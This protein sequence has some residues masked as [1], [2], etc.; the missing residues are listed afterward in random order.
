[1]LRL[2]YFFIAIILCPL[3]IQGQD[4]LLFENFNSCSF[5]SEW[6][7]KLTGNQ[8][9]KW[10]V[11]LP[12]NSK[13]KESSING[14]CMLYIDDDLTGDKT[15]PFKLRI[16]TP[17][18]DGSQYTDLQLN[19]LVHFRR[20]KTEYMKIIVDNGQKEFVIREFKGRNYSGEL[21][22]N[23]INMT[24][25]LSYYVSDSMRIIIEYD[26]DNQWAWWAG[27]D[28]ISITGRKGGKIILGETFNDCRLPDGWST[29]IVNGVNDW[30]FGYFTDGRSIDGSC[31]IYFNDD[32]LG[33]EA[34]LSKIRIYSPPFNASEYANYILTYDFIFRFYEPSEYFQLFVDNGK[35]LKTVKTYNGDFG[36]PNVD[37]PK[38][39]TI[40]LSPFRDEQVRLVWEYNDG[41]WAWW[42]G[43]DNVKITAQGDINDQCNKSKALTTNGECELFD[44]TNALRDDELSLV[45]D[46]HSG[47]MYY[48]FEPTNTDV[49]E[50][51]TKSQFNDIIEVLT[52]NCEAAILTAR[53]DKDEYGFQGENLSW[54]ATAGQKYI[55][56]IYGKQAEFGLEKGSGCISIKTNTIVPD[57][58]QNEKCMEA[59]PILAN[60]NCILYKNINA[61]L[62][63]GTPTTNH[64]S[65]ADIWFTFDPIVSGDYLFI[66]NADFADALAVFTGM[67]DSLTELKSSFSGH[68]ILLNAAQVGQQYHIQVTGYFATLEGT[69]CPEIKPTQ[70]PDV[71]HA[72]C[73]DALTLSMNNTCTTSY[74]SG[75]GFSGI[76]PSCDVY[77]Y[78]DVW[79]QFVAPATK[80]VY[81]KVKTDFENILSLYEGNCEKRQSIYCGKNIH[82]CNG[83]LHIRH[84]DAGKTYFIQLGSRTLQNQNKSGQICIEIKD[85]EPLWQKI[86]L[87]V[88]QECVSKGAVKF[89]P[90]A[91][92]GNGSYT[93]A[94]M[95][96]LD[97]VPGGD[98]YIIEATDGDGC[99]SAVLV[100]AIGCKDFGCTV[101]SQLTKKDVSCHGMN[102]GSVSIDLDGGLEPYQVSWSNG[103]TT[104][105]NHLLTAGLYTVTITDASGCELESAIT[106]NQPTQI[107]SNPTM[108][109]PKCY[110][111]TTGMIS[112]FVIGGNGQFTYQWED[113][114]TSPTL[115]KITGGLHR[116]TITDA[117]G[118]SVMETFDLIQPDEIK[119]S[120]DVTNIL[121]YG[122]QNGQIKVDIKGGTLP[123]SY[124]WA[125]GTPT[126]LD[127]LGAG[128][129]TLTI[130]DGH[131][132]TSTRTWEIT[133][134]AAIAL[135]VDS[136]DLV[137]TDTKLGHLKISMSGGTPPYLYDWYLDDVSL[138]QQTDHINL[139]ETGT[140]HVIVTDA[141]GC[142]YTSTKWQAAKI[143]STDGYTSENTLSI[144]PN[145][146]TDLLYI[147]INNPT[148][149]EKMYIADIFGNI[150]KRIV[151]KTNTTQLTV[152]DLT[153]GTYFIHWH[154]DDVRYS[155]K[156]VVVR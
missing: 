63:G 95:G 45:D 52:G 153:P 78:D 50:I 17:Y 15:P 122:D 76:Q 146:A 47:F 91:S 94:G 127:S 31:F 46:N 112:L 62:D 152:S 92:G 85:T 10:G 20:D 109:S 99:V 44:N 24:S 117:T 9:V 4:T 60:A 148:I 106:I 125:N 142:T 53:I 35:E 107:I 59:R 131:L 98:Q 49:F 27:L 81:I 2:L 108:T 136:L 12:T 64:R 41:G 97:V 40:D 134:P 14:T 8:N 57:T 13:A 113:G 139:R 116:V 88:Q 137:I 66:S 68:Q 84:L 104:L 38:K 3:F 124:E 19:A 151:P 86:S 147:Q 100:D 32:A 43:M 143:S 130:T 69:L 144:H 61:K 29:E 36:G 79:Y 123:Y 37:N 26:D 48:T 128:S 56:R 96:I 71:Q 74:N 141:S 126:L 42:L 72:N 21:F 93:Y 135:T 34:P 30:Q 1:M 7:Y 55:I 105:T 149:I 102:D 83:Y 75:A 155:S 114:S 119:I 18:F 150:I 28:D 87:D 6:S 65:R 58:P 67:C 133:Q 16:F 82:H 140:Y 101:S 132:C 145:P 118:C 73:T 70:S 103:K 156:V 5:P 80:E 121:C 25:D 129:Y 23:F 11:G 54:Q 90:S 115:D 22:S 120:A 89:V 154:V 111:D 138:G 33:K 51:Q 110:N 39:D 77:I